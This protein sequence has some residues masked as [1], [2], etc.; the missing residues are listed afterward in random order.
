MNHFDIAPGTA[1]PRQA[2]LEVAPATFLIRAVTPS[3][4]E[5]WTNLNSMVIRAAE[6]IVVDTGMVTDR[7]QWFEDVFSLVAPDDLRWIFVTHND[8]DHS[9][10][11]VEALSRCPNATLVTSPGESF[12]SHASFGI[13]HERMR[14]VGNDEPFCVGDRMLRPVRPPV[15]D[16]PYTRGVFDELTRVYYASDAFCAPMPDHPVDWVSEIAPERWAEGS[17][18]F[19]HASLCPWL[20]LVDAAAFRAE[21]D[22]LAR[23]EIDTILSAHSPAIGRESVPRALAQLASL[24]GSSTD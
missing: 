17:A 23:L 12:R 21:V 4:G 5:S 22:R 9:G 15:Y 2:P 10:N 6:P 8:S 14:L 13:A 11:M 3:V 18:R 19:H 24:P 7:E 16:S 20:S 1:R